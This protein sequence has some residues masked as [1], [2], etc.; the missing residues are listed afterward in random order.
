MRKKT[1]EEFKEE[2]HKMYKEEYRVL[3]EYITAKD[4]IKMKHN[5]CGNVFNVMPT[6]FLRGTKCPNCFGTPRKTTKKFK[7]E[8]YN[9]VKGEY[10]VLGEYTNS[11]TKVTMKH[12]KCGNIYE[13]LSTAFLYQGARCPKCSAIIG[14]KKQRKT[15]E[16]FKKEVKDLVGDEYTVLGEYINTDTK[17][18]VKHTECGNE[19]EVT[20]NNFLKGK[21]CPKCAIK[22]GIEAN[23]YRGYL[24]KEH[25]E[26]NRLSLKHSLHRW[27]TSVIERDNYK[28]IICEEKDKLE[29]HH[30]DGYHWC[31]SRRYDIDNGVTLCSECHK[32]FHSIYTTKNNT[33]EQF[34]E[35]IGQRKQSIS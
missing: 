25:R 17:I 5:K 11:K 6:N 16:K 15:I 34:E 2:V 18:K 31:K 4:N 10:E 13:V 33:E 23:N 14:G 12:I 21:R 35:F 28:C 27:R 30:L 20:P 26:R 3:G 24:S 9:L 22:T 7:K 1:T 8:V 29:V 19:Y 32:E